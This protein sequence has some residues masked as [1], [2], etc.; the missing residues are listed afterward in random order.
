MLRARVPETAVD[1]HDDLRPR[2]DDVGAPS[3]V[4]VERSL[5]PTFQG[6]GEWAAD[7]LG[8]AA[9][10]KA[11]WKAAMTVQRVDAEGKPL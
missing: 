5:H 2:E 1:E 8:Y 9:T 7:Q 6:G 11:G 10:I 3:T 4:E